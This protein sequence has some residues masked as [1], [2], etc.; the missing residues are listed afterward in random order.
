MNIMARSRREQLREGGAPRR[1]DSFERVGLRP[2][3]GRSEAAAR[4]LRSLRLDGRCPSEAGRGGEAE[5]GG[6]GSRA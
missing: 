4:S 2:T 1:K 5:R 3:G 6:S